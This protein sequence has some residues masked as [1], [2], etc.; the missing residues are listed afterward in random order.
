[1]FFVSFYPAA[2]EDLRASTNDLKTVFGSRLISIVRAK[3]RTMAGPWEEIDGSL[4]SAPTQWE[5]FSFSEQQ[6]KSYKG[7]VWCRPYLKIY[8]C[9]LLK[10]K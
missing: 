3:S 4:L 9:T 6:P 8:H 1:M 7:H 5:T 2:S 10:L